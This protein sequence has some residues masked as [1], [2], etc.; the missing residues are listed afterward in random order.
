MRIKN[1]YM[2]QAIKK[3]IERMTEMEYIT[4]NPKVNKDILPIYILAEIEKITF[5]DMM[6]Y[7]ISGTN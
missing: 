3:G 5:R 1:K 7:L 4:L 6:R 2:E